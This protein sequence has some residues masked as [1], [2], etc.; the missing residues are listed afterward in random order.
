MAQSTYACP[1][2]ITPVA[3]IYLTR[4]FERCWVHTKSFL[5][6]YYSSV[7]IY[8]FNLARSTD[9]NVECNMAKRGTAAC[10]VI[11]EELHS[12]K[13]WIYTAGSKSQYSS[14][15]GCLLWRRKGIQ[16]CN[17]NV[18]LWIFFMVPSLVVFWALNTFAVFVSYLGLLLSA[19]HNES[20]ENQSYCSL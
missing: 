5:S 1:A 16:V 10:W 2:C 15:C 14:N 8:L 13:Y 9:I 20:V 7:F 12:D 3:H 18:L 4:L 11:P 6:N 19:E 17:R